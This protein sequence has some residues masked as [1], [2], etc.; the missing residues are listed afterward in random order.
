[1]GNSEIIVV[2]KPNS[3]TWEAIA[4]FLQEAFQGEVKKGI[5]Y[6]LSTL[7]AKKYVE[8]IKNSICFVALENDILKGAACYEWKG[9]D[10]YWVVVGVAQDCRGKG[11]AKALLQEGIELGKKEKA[12]SLTLYTASRASTVRFYENLGFRKIGYESFP[13]TNT[14]SIYFYL[15]LDGR[16]C[17]LE[18]VRFLCSML[19][20]KSMKRADGKIRKG[21]YPFYV[22]ARSFYRKIR[23]K[24]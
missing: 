21:V 13:A 3:M 15:P 2:P 14:Y 23:G 4:R 17:S 7:S 6:T 22:L 5:I 11:V 16:G 24:K 20:C 1:M 12:K 10:L 9:K 19:H 18:R 8:R